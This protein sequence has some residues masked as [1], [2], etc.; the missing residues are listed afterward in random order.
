MLVFVEL[1]C[2]P[3]LR[4]AIDPNVKG[5]EYYGPNGRKQL[6]GYPVKVEMTKMATNEE[7]ASRLFDISENLTGV[8]YEF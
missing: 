2:L 6:N 3:T 4:A 5:G 8:K 1:G 7:Y